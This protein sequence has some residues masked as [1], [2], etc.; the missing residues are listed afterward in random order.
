M[1]VFEQPFFLKRII[2]AFVNYL[3]AFRAAWQ[4][5]PIGAIAHRPFLS[6]SFTQQSKPQ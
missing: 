5:A 2:I 3:P 4:L 1:A 6:S